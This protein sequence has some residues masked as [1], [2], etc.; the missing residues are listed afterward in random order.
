[1]TWLCLVAANVIVP[2]GDAPLNREV[3]VTVPEWYLLPAMHG[4]QL[5]HASKDAPSRFIE[6]K[7]LA[8][9]LLRPAF[10]NM[11]INWA[12]KAWPLNRVQSST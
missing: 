6:P 5:R 9:A 2:D 10:K 8:E 1:M 4:P 7:Q 12:T 11:K 3:E